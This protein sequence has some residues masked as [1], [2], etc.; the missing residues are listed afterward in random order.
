MD[1]PHQRIIDGDAPCAKRH[2]DG[3]KPIDGM[4]RPRLPPAKPA[5]RPG[6]WARFVEQRTDKALAR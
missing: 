4:A 1:H 3:I 6:E 5:V 2:L